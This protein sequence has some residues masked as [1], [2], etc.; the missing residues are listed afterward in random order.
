MKRRITVDPQVCHGLACITGARIPVC[1]ILGMMANGDS[2]ED[3]LG[4]YPSLKREDI[5]ACL[6]Y[7]ALLAE[8]QMAPFEALSGAP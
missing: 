1:Q 6:E 8:E 7:G 2:I 5:L 3:L 4:E